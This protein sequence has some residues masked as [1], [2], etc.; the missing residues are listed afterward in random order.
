[1]DKI[2]TYSKSKESCFDYYFENES[3][4]RYLV[5]DIPCDKRI[6]D[7]QIEMIRK[8]SVKGIIPLNPMQKNNSYSMYYNISSKISLSEIFKRRELTK[9]EFINIMSNITSVIL[10]SKEFLLYENSFILSMDLIF[11]EDESLDVSMV[12]VPARLEKD[13]SYTF[14]EYLTN[15]V[16]MLAQINGVNNRIYLNEIS[17]YLK[18][19]NFSILKFHS[20]IESMRSSKDNEEYYLESW[21][22]QEEAIQSQF[23]SL[24]ENEELNRLN[25]EETQTDTQRN[26]ETPL[27]GAKRLV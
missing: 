9:D 7:Y 1:M 19:H 25:Q 13:I 10:K 17:D 27:Q 11:I 3:T 22:S 12:Y 14:K 5:I 8:N 20:F 23:Q 24:F 26:K 6:I 2:L 4:S 21:V 15:M 16:T 18:K